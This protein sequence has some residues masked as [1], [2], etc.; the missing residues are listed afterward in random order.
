MSTNILF[1]WFLRVRNSGRAQLGGSGFWI[2][3]IVVVKWWLELEQSRVQVAGAI[4]ICLSLSLSLHTDSGSLHSVS[5][6]RLV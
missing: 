3:Y 6:L 2:S 1:S 4:C 5:P